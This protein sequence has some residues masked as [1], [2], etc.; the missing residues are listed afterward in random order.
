M[1]LSVFVYVCVCTRVRA[2]VRVRWVKGYPLNSPYIGSSPAL[3]HLLQEKMPF[4]CLRLDKV[5][6][7]LLLP[8]FPSTRTILP[9]YL[10][11]LR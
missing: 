7:R 11:P 9:P 10:T 2:Y 3:C 1:F 4:C 5:G 6:I 8:Y